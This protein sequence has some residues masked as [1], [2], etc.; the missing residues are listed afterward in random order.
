MPFLSTDLLALDHST[1]A[2]FLRNGE[3]SPLAAWET[4]YGC[5]H[6]AVTQEPELTG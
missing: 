2:N 4:H 5:S 6:A 3:R 1:F